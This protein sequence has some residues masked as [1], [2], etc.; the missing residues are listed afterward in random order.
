MRRVP[1]GAVALVLVTAAGVGC[2]EGDSPNV[3]VGATTTSTPSTTTTGPVPEPASTAEPG[4]TTTTT[5]PIP[6]GPAAAPDELA[7]QLALAEGEIRD[8]DTPPE[9][10][11]AAGRLQQQVYRALVPHPEWDPIVAAGLPEGLRPVLDANL[12]AGRELAALGRRTFAT[13]P[14]WRILAPAPPEELRRYYDE[15][16]A[17]FGVPWEY[18][19][20]IHLVETRT[21]RIDGLSTAGAQG[22]MQFLPSTWAAYGT[23]DIED[24]HDAILG[25]ARYLQANGAPTRM[26]DALYR[27]NPTPKYVN[28]VT[29]YAEQIQADPRAYLGY[30]QWEVWYSTVLGDVLLPVGYDSP[31]ER[32]VTPEDLPG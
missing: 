12:A 15:G 31:V 26:A 24:T 20:A 21:G 14:A 11:G 1:I 17:T 6:A 13:L 19:A 22:P 25:A 29:A 8:P 18:L 16:Q 27:Y 32:P 10:I 3:A 30:H 23:G 5:V 9:R 7:R 2:A 28:A 4:V